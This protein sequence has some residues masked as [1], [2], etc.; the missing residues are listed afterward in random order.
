MGIVRL[1]DNN[2]INKI[3]AGEVVERP[4]SCV[5][6]LVENAID[7]GASHIEVEILNGGK[8]LMRVT[9]DG[10][11]MSKEDSLLAIK[12]HA[13]SKLSNVRDLLNIS[14]LGFR[15]EAVPT[16]AAVSKFTLQTRQKNS[17]LGT[18][19]QIEGG[20]LIDSHEIG[21]KT[22][23]T[24]IVEDLFFNTPA[25]LKFLKATAS[26]SSK[27]HEYIVKLAL[28]RP[29][30]S[31][32]F[33]N[34]NRPALSTPGNGKMI[35][36]ITGVYG[37][38]ISSSLIELNFT[39]EDFKISGYIGKP[40]FLKNYR[41]W[42][43]FIINGRIVNNRTIS[44]ALEESYRALIPKSGFPLAVLK[45][46]VPQS[47]IDVNVHPQ[48]TELRFED[49]NKIFRMVYRAVREAVS[50]RKENAES[51][52][53]TEIAAPPD[54]PQYEPL[55]LEEYF[56]KPSDRK[57]FSV[58]KARENLNSQKENLTAPPQNSTGK[59]S[60]KEIV[61]NP[62]EKNL[63]APTQNSTEKNPVKEVVENPVEKNLTAP[64]Q[65]STEKN[66][67]KE[68]IENPVEKNLTAPPQNSTEK[69]P[70][71]EIVENPVEKNLTAPPQKISKPAFK[72]QPIG[73]VNLCYIVAQSDSD[74]YIIDQHA[75]HER[76]L[77]DRLCSYADKIPAQGLLIHRILKFDERET[78]LIENNLEIFQSLGFTMEP[79]GKN[80]FR[81]LEV[82]VDAAE[83]DP[84]D[85]LREIIS[86][87]PEID[88]PAEI[89]AERRADIA[90]NIRQLVL[91]TTACKAAIKA[92]QELN[93]RQMQ[94][95]LNDLSKTPNPHTCPHGR[96]TIIKFSSKDLAKMFH[97]E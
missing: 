60:V 93:S 6:E 59:N 9:D 27:I 97:R 74:L 83:T 87:L 10:G 3:A 94:V 88:N 95:L 75:A 19:I 63:T 78:L 16:I 5:K 40:N 4:A 70:V 34:N 51:H 55:N 49:D 31:F 92:G 42:Q 41:T 80:E 18:K 1:L 64:P 57:N 11:G 45:I 72:L 53:L 67:V 69:N 12:R 25:R 13:T 28:S 23:T 46:E 14:T 84:E 79:S 85:M 21:C 89:D 90:R 30:I 43:T 33:I 29:E 48:K 39:V 81:L 61:E 71:K 96:P 37:T 66:P 54:N 15:G 52:D 35:D 91:A 24:V 7:A 32:K 77:F 2:T 62:V 47:S 82:P 44:K 36:V 76:I 20:K 8:T 86:S 56:G 50:E 17:E 22:G 58:E 68:I 65:N 73:Q 26:E 38:E